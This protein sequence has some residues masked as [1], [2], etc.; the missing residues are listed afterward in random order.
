MKPAKAWGLERVAALFAGLAILLQAIAVPPARA[1]VLEVCTA[2]GIEKVLAPGEAPAMP[3]DCDHC[4][5]CVLAPAGALSPLLVGAAAAIR[6][7]RAVEPAMERRTSARGAR[8]PPRPP[9]QGPPQ[10]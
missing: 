10:L 2:H 5:A 8:A 1:Q 4:G 6:Y 7:A 9:G 3:G